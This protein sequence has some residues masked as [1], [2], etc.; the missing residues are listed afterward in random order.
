MRHATAR[1]VAEH[2]L[3]LHAGTVPAAV[4][5]RRGLGLGHFK[6]HLAYLG[7]YVGELCNAVNRGWAHASLA[8][9]FRVPLEQQPGR[10]LALACSH[11]VRMQA[12]PCRRRA[13]PVP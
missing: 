4:E 12:G 5:H 3:Q 6:R 9:G 13:L 11:Q 7:A 8:Q 2:L 1:Y 10:G